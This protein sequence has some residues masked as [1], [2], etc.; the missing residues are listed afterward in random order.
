[1]SHLLHI[2]APLHAWLPTICLAQ[3]REQQMVAK[4]LFDEGVVAA[5]QVV[6]AGIE[7]L[8]IPADIDRTTYLLSL[9]AFMPDHIP[10]GADRTMTL[11]GPDQFWYLL[12]AIMCIA[13]PG[14]FLL[15][16]IYTKAVIVRSLE[17]ADYFIFLAFP[18]IIAEVVMGYFMVKWGAGVHQW[19]ITLDQLFHQ[20]YWAN[21]GQIIYCPLSFVVKMAI[22]LQYLRLF[23][24]GRS[25]N[26][27]MW[28]GA[29][30][31]MI[32]C[33]ILYTVLMFWTM[34]Y[35]NPREAIW[36]KLTPDAKCHDVNHIIVA[37]GAFNMGSDIVIL[38]LPTTSLWQLNV[39]LGRKIAVTML[40]A[41]G[42]LAC[43]ASAM[44]IV[45][46]VKIA[47]VISEADVSHNGLFIG[48]WTEAEVSLGFIV[49]CALCLP[50]LVQAKGMKLK[51]AMTK[52][53]SP[54]SSLRGTVRSVSRRP[55]FPSERSLTGIQAP[56][57]SRDSVH[58]ELEQFDPSTA[59]TRHER[60]YQQHTQPHEQHQRQPRHKMHMPA[61][62]LQP[63]AYAQSATAGSSIYS[64]SPE[65]H[66]PSNRDRSVSRDSSI[67]VAPLRVSMYSPDGRYL[68]AR[69]PAR[70]L[71]RS[72]EQL[73]ADLE[74]LQQT[75]RRG[76]REESFS[77]DYSITIPVP[78]KSPR[79]LSCYGVEERHANAGS[80]Q[81]LTREE[82]T[83][84]QL[85]AEVE[86]LRQFN[87]EMAGQSMEGAKRS[88]PVSYAL[89][90]QQQY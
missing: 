12:V 46:T 28:Y 4:A 21:L 80:L 70:Q 88:R 65:P 23:A 69:S 27:L 82:M 73:C 64:Q 38:L 45:F 34:F 11:D 74:N 71:S 57:S 39:P 59:A 76:T 44:R 72:D 86:M 75:G 43:A 22:L 81:R 31:T 53:S 18:L 85:R 7:K 10:P 30:A 60:Y 67:R 40:F 14:V 66:R 62:H 32:S 19:Q 50:K 36:N 87:F 8:T 90:E 89:P 37:Q 42:L 25:V 20:L 58:G 17:V 29:W 61:G 15:I 51:R 63:K 5:R 54:F 9:P 35:C 6:P 79:R 52:A 77:R 78:P 33:A 48:L 3:R 47:P 24:P 41:T 2:F 1:M 56:P 16:R 83:A 26:K 13:I 55:T 68:G 84:E 49:A